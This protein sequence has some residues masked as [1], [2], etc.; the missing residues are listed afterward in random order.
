MLRGKAIFDNPKP[1]LSYVEVSQIENLK[2]FGLP[3]NVLARPD[4]VLKYSIAD[5]QFQ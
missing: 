2:S 5:F 1:V 4:R 3:S